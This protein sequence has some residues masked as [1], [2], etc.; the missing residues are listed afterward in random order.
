MPVLNGYFSNERRKQQDQARGRES[1]DREEEETVRSSALLRVTTEVFSAVRVIGDFYTRTNPLLSNPSPP[2]ILQLG[3]G[4]PD[5]KGISIVG[6]PEGSLLLFPS[7]VVKSRNLLDLAM[8]QSRVL[9]DPI[10]G[11]DVGVENL[12]DLM[13]RVTTAVGS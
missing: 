2:V 5:N 3:V 9:I 1:Q 6:E 13:R 12:R 10:Q 8:E 4:S 11:V 7:G